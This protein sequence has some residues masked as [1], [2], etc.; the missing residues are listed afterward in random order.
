ME[1]TLVTIK[2]ASIS[3]LLGFCL[4]LPMAFA[5]VYGNRVI[6]GLVSVYER[7]ARSIPLL[8][9]LFLIF[10]GLPALKIRI[11][12]FTSAILALGLRGAAYQSQIYKGAILSVSGNQ[13]KAALSLGMNRLS[14]FFYVILPQS[15]RIAIPPI[16]NE[17]AIVLKDTSTVYAIGVSELLRQGHYFI[18]TGSDPMT[19][20]LSVAFIYLVMTICIKGLLT[21]FEKRYRIPGIGIEGENL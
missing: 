16:G 6:K 3:L 10:Y 5:Q 15:V 12:A 13:M 4:G 18:S 14:A 7:V 9:I 1:G 11:P 2:L 19:I 21:L 17:A 8:V 20:Y